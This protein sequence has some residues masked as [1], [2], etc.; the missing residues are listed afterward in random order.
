MKRILLVVGLAVCTLAPAGWS[1]V[2]AETSAMP[3]EIV[4]VKTSGEQWSG[5]GKDW[6]QY[7]YLETDAP[8]PG[9]YL[10]SASFQLG[11]DRSCGSWSTCTQVLNSPY[12]AAWEFRMQG[13]DEVLQIKEFFIQFT[14][15]E[16][17]DLKVDNLADL[18]KKLPSIK[19]TVSGKR[20]TSTGVLAAVYRLEPPISG[21]PASVQATT[22]REEWSGEGRNYSDWYSLSSLSAPP[23][24]AVQRT[25]FHLE[26]DRSCGAWAECNEARRD[27]NSST[28]SFRLQGH[29]ESFPPNNRRR[30]T[31]ILTT[32]YVLSKPLVFHTVVEGNSLWL[33]AEHY[34][35]A[36]DWVKLFD[37]NR[38]SI[39]DPDLIFPG[40]VL[41]VPDL[42][43]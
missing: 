5:E 35:G 9:Y 16:K 40:Q 8:P 17:I 31:G 41:F 7:Y 19:V 11:G 13:H 3:A 42:R 15:G 10:Y 22:R 12:K 20:A 1:Q 24:Y 32:T 18:I 14:F 23:R 36:P 39:K 37:A 28:W 29:D 43:P 26:G 2:K 33:L 30:S 6:S 34:Y 25:E 21:L 38:K 4:T 27:A